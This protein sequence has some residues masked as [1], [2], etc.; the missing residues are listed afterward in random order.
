MAK[1]EDAVFKGI[2]EKLYDFEVF[3][4]DTVFPDLGAVY[5]FARYM[6]GF[7]CHWY[8]VLYVGETESLMDRIPHRNQMD[9]VNSYS[10]D[11]ICVHLDANESSRLSKH[12]D[13]VKLIG[14]SHFQSES[15]RLYIK[16]EPQW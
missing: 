6:P 15:D 2:S 7:D 8:E 9:S 3:S 5:I 12:E 16:K 13:L 10:V 11:A 4:T 1:L 14:T